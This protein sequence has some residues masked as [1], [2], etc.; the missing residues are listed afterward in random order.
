MISDLSLASPE[1][2]F[3]SLAASPRLLRKAFGE[4]QSG[5]LVRPHLLSFLV[6]VITNWPLKP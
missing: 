4:N 6:R 2:Y 5:T 1:H 3:P